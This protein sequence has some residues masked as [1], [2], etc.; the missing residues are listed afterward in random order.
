VVPITNRFDTL[1]NLQIDVESPCDTWNHSAKYQHS[2]K[3]AFHKKIKVRRPPIVKRKKIL[4]IGDSH[5]R[6]CSSE[7]GK[8]LGQDYQVSGTFMPGL[9]LRNL[10][11]KKLTALQR[12][13]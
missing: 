7:L 10:Q 5:V 2:K 11:R 3:I 9:G 6:G 12:K 8:Y 13:I 1:Y 4:L